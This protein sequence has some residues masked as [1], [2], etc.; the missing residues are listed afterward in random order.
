[1]RRAGWVVLALATR[2]IGAPAPF[3]LAKLRATKGLRVNQKSGY[4]WIA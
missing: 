3:V 2:S 1:M 4:L